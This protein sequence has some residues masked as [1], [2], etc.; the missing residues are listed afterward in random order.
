MN[1]RK[2][3]LITT[4]G[5]ALAGCGNDA[6]P[7]A[8]TAPAPGP[9]SAA[10]GSLGSGPAAAPKLVASA[11]ASVSIEG[12]TGVND[13]CNIEGVDRQLFT[14]PTVT[15]PKGGTHAFAGWIVDKAGNV[16]PTGLKLVVTG[17]GSTSGLFTS[18]AVTWVDRAGVGQTRGYGPELNKS[19]FVF[20]VDTADVPAGRY[21]VF[22]TG[23]GATGTVVC[24]PGRQVVIEG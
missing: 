10:D 3:L 7:P 19:G 23:A 5:V 13:D 9:Q 16:V 15:V 20:N 18:E 1:L 17:V 11:P 14:S 21:H 24:D 6:D 4:L 8:A 12:A 2:I 22:V